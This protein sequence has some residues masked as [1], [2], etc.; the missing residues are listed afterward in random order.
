MTF[1][2]KL[3]RRI[4]GFR[5]P[6]AAALL[7]SLFACDSTD[8]FNPDPT[9]DGDIVLAPAGG[10]ELAT[11]FAGGIPIGT[12]A[13]PNSEFG[14]LY[15]G[16]LRTIGPRPLISDLTAIR[17]RGG[18]IALMMAG[19]QTHYRNRDGTFSLTEWKA[20]IDLFR[21]VN[22]SSFINDGTIIAHYLID[23]PYDGHNFG[24][25]PVPGSTLEEMA[26]YSKSIWPNLKTV[27]RAEPYE[28]KWNGT[29]RHL[30][31]AW[32]QYLWRKGDVSD[33]IQ[34]N[35]STAQQMGLGL[36]VGLNLVHGGSPNGTWM[37]PSE[38][39]T[40]GS[41]LLSSD[42]PCAFI[43]WQYNS[44]MLSPSNMK[45]AMSRLRRKAESRPS[46]SC[47]A[48]SSG[49][50][51]PPPTEP[52]PPSPSAG[53]PFGPYGL[54]T[55][56]MGSFT[57]SVRSPTPSNVLATAAAAR[58]AGVRVILRLTGDD[59]ANTDGTFNLTKWKAALDRYAS[60]DLSSYASD[61]TIAGLLLVQNPHT[62]ETWGG[63]QI[64]HATLDEMARYSRQ[65]WPAIPT[66]ADAPPSWLATKATPWE[67]LDASSVMYFG[68]D[69]DA[70]AWVGQQASDAGRARLGLLVGMNVLNGGTSASRLPG[71]TEGKYA[72]SAAQLQSWG[73]ALVAQ[74]RVCGLVLARYDATYFGRS[75]VKA[76]VGIVAEEAGA[77]AATSCRVRS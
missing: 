51:T 60:A 68:S 61:G 36:I 17:S 63:R 21:N 40:W 64:S 28:I 65:R 48:A 34:K 33:Y 26:R 14:S 13:M 43:S 12:F 2:F 38:V 69:G 32:A 27:V 47:S 15:N 10:P 59:A 31:A 71:T 30:D 49:G 58:K 29:Y 24:G 1:K 7:L 25:K 76:A 9:D 74:N 4:A 8:S 22:F 62:A 5:A 50:Q 18:K 16:A 70:G 77:R 45:E 39:E 75:D 3:S 67:Y 44:S 72:M 37:T 56:E 57:G 66:I 54:P 55:S 53:V 20:R 41:A 23:E 35:V 52:P 46:R 19:P 11:A 6:V 73:S 42:Y